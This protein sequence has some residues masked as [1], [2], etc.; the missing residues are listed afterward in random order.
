MEFITL[1]VIALLC[2]ISEATRK[3]AIVLFALLFLAF[4]LTSIALLAIVIY[5][6]NKL[7]RRNYYEP[8]KLPR[9]N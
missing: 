2:L 1:V 6:T 5:I 7:N 4:P 3:M 8:P 9:S